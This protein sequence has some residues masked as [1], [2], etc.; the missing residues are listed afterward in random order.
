MIGRVGSIFGAHGINIVSA[1][2]GRH[3]DA[4]E[5][6]AG[7]IAAMAI[8]TD[9]AVPRAVIDEILEIDGFVAARTVSL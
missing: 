2:V 6:G 1:A 7:K 8:T 5:V 3:G 4:P 9:V